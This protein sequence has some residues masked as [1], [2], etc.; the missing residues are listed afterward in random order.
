MVVALENYY[1]EFIIFL[2]IFKFLNVHKILLLY[3]SF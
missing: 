3:I 2:K 1:C